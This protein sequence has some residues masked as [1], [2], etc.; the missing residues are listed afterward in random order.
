MVSS[1]S[2]SGPAPFGSL[3]IRCLRIWTKTLFVAKSDVLRIIR[4]MACRILNRSVPL[5]AVDSLLSVSQMHREISLTRSGA[6]FKLLEDLEPSWT[7]GADHIVLY[8]W[9]DIEGFLNRLIDNCVRE[10]LHFYAF[11]NSNLMRT[12][13]SPRLTRFGQASQ[14]A[15]Y[16]MKHSLGTTNLVQSTL[17]LKMC[18]PL[19]T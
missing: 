18:W 17:T 2:P 12:L 7:R 10:L 15:V 4:V 11:I 14:I 8:K 3:F 1:N 19:M 16:S 13:S 5:K 9:D 6:Y